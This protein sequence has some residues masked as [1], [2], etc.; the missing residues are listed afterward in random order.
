MMPPMPEVT[1][2]DFASAAMSGDSLAA[3]GVLQTLLGLEEGA[4]RAAAEHFRAAMK[5]QGQPFLMRAMGLRNA[6]GSG[7]DEDMRPLLMECFGLSGE[8]L[9]GALASL[10]ARYG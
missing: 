9:D 8:P 10:R 2:R 4:A 1:F 3:T 6:V 7:R 5:D